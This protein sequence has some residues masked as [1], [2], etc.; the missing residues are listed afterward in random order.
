MTDLELLRKN[1]S[2]TAEPYT[3]ADPVMQG[4]LDRCG[5]DVNLAASQ[6]WIWRAG[7]AALRNFKYKTP[8][9][10]SID[11]TMT[12]GECREQAAL[13]RSMATS[14]P[15]DVTVEVDWTEAFDPVEGVS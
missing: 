12:A 15:A 9:G 3:W 2:D 14:E 4:L 5:G 10:T 8:D 11:K 1:V 6:V 7:D 13:Y